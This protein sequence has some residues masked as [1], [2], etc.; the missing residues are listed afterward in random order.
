MASGFSSKCVGTE[1]DPKKHNAM[2]KMLSPAFARRELLE[3][4]DI[5][6]S[7]V[8]KF[9]RILGEKGG[10]GTEGLNMTKWYQMATFDVLGEMAFGES[11]HSLD[12]GKIPQSHFHV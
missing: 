4:E 5:I 1:R 9:V 6:A 11:F 8:D 10:S 12:D 3:Q 7:V 2:R